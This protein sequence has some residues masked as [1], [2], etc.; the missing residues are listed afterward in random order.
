MSPLPPVGGRI[1]SRRVDTFR[2]LI[3]GPETGKELFSIPTARRELVSVTGIS[4]DGNLAD[5]NSPGV[6]P[7]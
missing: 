2:D 1:Y 4:K 6:G 3:H 5:V 7:R